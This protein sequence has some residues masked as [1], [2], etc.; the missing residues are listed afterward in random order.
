L[1]FGKAA[2][3][4]LDAAGKLAKLAGGVIQKEP[5][6]GVHTSKDTI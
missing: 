5:I 3:A 6:T 1:F 2:Q 4:I